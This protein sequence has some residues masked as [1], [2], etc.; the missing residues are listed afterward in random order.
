ANVQIRPVDLV[1][2]RAGKSEIPSILNHS[3]QIDVEMALKL[4]SGAFR[5]L[6]RFRAEAEFGAVKGIFVKFSCTM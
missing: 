3:E 4:T 5:F 1:V 6:A 2:G